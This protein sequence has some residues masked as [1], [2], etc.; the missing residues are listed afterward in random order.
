M[1]KY[2]GKKPFMSTIMLTEEA[3]SS[4]VNILA[5]PKS[6]ETTMHLR[7]NFQ[8]PKNKRRRKIISYQDECLDLSLKIY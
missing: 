6:P 8:I 5:S 2:N 4:E 3:S 1:A 7:N